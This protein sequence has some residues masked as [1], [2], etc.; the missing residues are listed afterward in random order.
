MNP[1]L[2]LSLVFDLYG[3]S[4]ALLAENAKLKERIEEITQSGHQNAGN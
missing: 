2:V 1:E 3:Q 4:V